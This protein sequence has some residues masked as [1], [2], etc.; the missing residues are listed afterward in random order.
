M[1][2]AAHGEEATIARIDPLP[3]LLQRAIWVALAPDSAA[4]TLQ[5]QEV[6]NVLGRTGRASESRGPAVLAVSDRWIPVC[7]RMPG[8]ARRTT[9]VRPRASARWQRDG[10][11][12]HSR[13]GH[14]AAGAV[15]RLPGPDVHKG[16]R[17]LDVAHGCGVWRTERAVL[18]RRTPDVP[19]RSRA[20]QELRDGLEGH[21]I[22]R[23]EK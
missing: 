16:V 3:F 2:R 5:R 6:T 10:S 9:S 19:A 4:P 13:E 22:A 14:C 15:I 8:D 1:S 7:A 12:R 18:S 21:E 23:V 20:L 11:C 17:R